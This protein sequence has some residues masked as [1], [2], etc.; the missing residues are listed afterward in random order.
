MNII[1]LNIGGF[2]FALDRGG[3]FLR[4]PWAGE[5]WLDFTGQGLT[6]W[7]RAAQS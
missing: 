2:T 3:V 7:S 6:C 4:L 5:G 1:N